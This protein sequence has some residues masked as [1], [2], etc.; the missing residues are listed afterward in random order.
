M[1][2]TMSLS[3]FKDNKDLKKTDGKKKGMLEVFQN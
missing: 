1:E 2:T 3:A